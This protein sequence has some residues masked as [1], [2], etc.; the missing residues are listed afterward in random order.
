LDVSIGDVPEHRNPG[1]IG[2]QYP[3]TPKQTGRA[4]A[5]C[6]PTR[7]LMFEMNEVIASNSYARCNE[8][9]TYKLAVQID[10]LF[11][12]EYY[13]TAWLSNTELTAQGAI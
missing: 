1:W 5:I 6:Q 12:H 11:D 13:T 4:F 7:K 3:H 8:N 10:N 2:Q 9:N